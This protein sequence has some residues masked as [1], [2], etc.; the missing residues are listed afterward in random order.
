MPVIQQAGFDYCFDTEAC[1]EC[2][3]FCCRGAS[4]HVWIGQGDVVRMSGFLKLNTVDFLAGYTERT[5][6]RLV[7]RE[8]RSADGFACIFFDRG[9]NRC[10]IYPV[11]PG[12]CR[13]FPFWNYFRNHREELLRECPGIRECRQKGGGCS[14]E[15]AG[16]DCSRSV[17]AEDIPGPGR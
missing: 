13:S 11:R 7:L 6:N 10:T 12:Q 14:D 3:G 1:G 5:D 17:P 4:G 9:R 2:G 16:E 8:R 15:C